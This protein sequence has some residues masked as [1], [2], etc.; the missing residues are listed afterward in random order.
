[1]ALTVKLSMLICTGY[2][3]GTVYV[4]SLVS[5][6]SQD[7]S[8]VWVADSD[9]AG[10][11]LSAY[12]PKPSRGPVRFAPASPERQPQFATA[13]PL[14]RVPESPADYVVSAAP[15][16]VAALASDVSAPQVTG[17]IRDEYQMATVSG[18]A[19]ANAV[20][21]GNDDVLASAAP[22]SNDVGLTMDNDADMGQ[23]SEYIVRQGDTLSRIATLN[24]GDPR[25]I[26]AIVAENNIPNP[27]V[28]QPGMKLRLPAT[29][30]L[31]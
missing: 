28:I 17:A 30:S 7:A 8:S 1:M 24:Y 20:E 21:A 26:Y 22:E 9:E 29:L 11:L 23:T 31:R 4:V 3:A 5:V 12:R 27:D 2:I 14:E 25:A 10:K 16:E 19:S 15:Q 13:G 6:P 18:A